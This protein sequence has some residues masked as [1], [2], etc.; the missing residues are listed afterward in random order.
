M[1]IEDILFLA[2]SVKMNPW[3]STLVY[4][5]QDQLT[6]GSGLTEKQATLAVRVLG[7]YINKLN[8]SASQDLTLYITNPKFKFNIRTLNIVKHISVINHSTYNRSLKVEFPYNEQIISKIRA[9]K[10]KLNSANW[11]PELK[12][13]IFSL[14]ER[15]IIF[16][17]DLAT[18]FGFSGDDEFNDFAVQARTI[19][20]NLEDYIPNL[21]RDGDQYKFNNVSHRVPQPISNNLIDALFE[22]RQAGINTWD[23]TIDEQL[24]QTEISSVVRDFLKTS[25]SE[26]F[27]LNTTDHSLLS[28]GDIVKS[29]LPCLIVIPGGSELEKLTTSVTF[30]N[31]IGI[32]NSEISVLFR[33]PKVTGD[34]FNNFIRN[35]NINNPVTKDTKAV[36]ISSKIPKTLLDP[37]K[38]FNCVINFNFYSIHYTI[39]D[40][41][42]WH[43]NVISVLEK[44]SNN[45]TR[46]NNF[47]DM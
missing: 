5:L 45:E 21:A 4:S 46:S 23:E 13:W 22:A 26:I 6:K 44:K 31:E 38:E 30:L 33:L 34:D 2:T 10:A 40:F 12:A 1:Y 17:A 14:D 16:L 19:Q 15:S 32:N 37:R 43:H 28:A 7:R 8:V 24:N 42:K 20:S 11:D 27:S 39:R 18:E 9:E 47:G 35:N 41:L 3:D 25:P 29:L 36:F